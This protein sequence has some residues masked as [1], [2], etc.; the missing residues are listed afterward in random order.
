MRTFLGRPG[1]F[2][3]VVMGGGADWVGS[4]RQWAMAFLGTAPSAT[5]KTA[6]A[7]ANRPNRVPMAEA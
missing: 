5:P 4:G 1:I 6:T 2:L 3:I 7:Q